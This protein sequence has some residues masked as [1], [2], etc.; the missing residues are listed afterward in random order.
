MSE[1]QTVFVVLGVLGVIVG[2]L[3]IGWGIAYLVGRYYGD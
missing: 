3:M 1:S 2:C